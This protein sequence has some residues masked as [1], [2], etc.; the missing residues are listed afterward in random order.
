[1]PAKVARINRSVRPERAGLD[2][3]QVKR[4]RGPRGSSPRPR[5]FQ[6][7][8][9]IGRSDAL[10]AAGAR[11][12]Q[13][14]QPPTEVQESWSLGPLG[15]GGL[16][17][18]TRSG[19]RSRA[20]SRASARFPAENF[21]EKA[22]TAPRRGGGRRHGGWGGAG[23]WVAGR[24]VRSSQAAEV[25]PPSGGGL[26]PEPP[27]L[28]RAAPSRPRGLGGVGRSGTV[29]RREV[30]TAPHGA[31]QFHSLLCGHLGPTRP[32]GAPHGRAPRWTPRGGDG[33]C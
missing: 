31:R 16:G 17:R 27:S 19:R 12:L 2:P 24:D 8:A 33:V 7:L 29:V 1:M 4:R 26:P 18:A 6:V 22:A 13:S 21:G 25:P 14:A 3:H 10:G 11:T 32:G 5:T 20:P 30:P 9:V 15:S 28:S 23:H